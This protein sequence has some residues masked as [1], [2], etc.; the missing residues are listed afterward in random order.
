MHALI[1]RVSTLAQQSGLSFPGGEDLQTKLLKAPELA[2]PRRRLAKGLV[3]WLREHQTPPPELP[4]L[5]AEA[6]TW[7]WHG[8]SA[9]ECLT[10]GLL[11]VYLRVLR[12]TQQHAALLR[13]LEHQ[14]HRPRHD[15]TWLNAALSGLAS[16]ARE[17][18]DL[19]TLRRVATQLA[20]WFSQAGS[21]T[22]LAGLSEANVQALASALLRT[23][24]HSG[25]ARL[26]EA[27]LHDKPASLDADMAARLLQ[28][29]AQHLGAATA[30]PWAERAVAQ[31]PK[32]PGVRLALLHAL[33]GVGAGV[34]ELGPITQGVDDAHPSYPNFLSGVATRA[35]ESGH[36][37]AALGT[38]RELERRGHLSDL[39]AQQLSHLSIQDSSIAVTAVSPDLSALAPLQLALAPLAALLKHPPEHGTPL[40][41]AALRQQGE[42]ALAHFD[43]T[44]GQPPQLSISQ[45]VEAASTLWAMANA[46]PLELHHWRGV[47]PFDFGPD[48][49]RLDPQRA[50]VQCEAVLTHLLSL[51]RHHLG[52]L[53]HAACGQINEILR[54]AHWHCEAQWALGLATE[55]QAD[56]ASLQAR[57]APLG[58]WAL[59]A[60]RERCALEAGDLPAARM[61]RQHL[62]HPAPSQ[63][64]PAC[65]WAA[66]LA[67]QGLSEQRLCSDPAIGGRWDIASPK[68]RL[69]TAHFATLPT[70]L[71]M[72]ATRGLEVRHGHLLLSPTS[73][74][75]LPQAWHRQMGAFPFP[76]PKLLNRG[77]WGATL[78]VPDHI[79]RVS[80]PLL[81]LANM[82]ATFH[83]NYYHW[84]VLTL[85]RLHWAHA[86]GL[87]QGRR[88]LL[89]AELPG[90]MFQ[91]LIDAGVPAESLRR[92]RQDEALRLD[93]ALLLSPQEWASATQIEALCKTLWRSA[94]LN[95]E[96][97][98]PAQRLL[99]L[100]RHGEL[101]R[102][103]AQAQAVADLAAS[104]GFECVAPE[105]LS[106]LDQVRLFAQARGIAGPPGAAFTNLMW[107]QPGTKVLTVFKDEIN[108]PTFLDLSF[109]KGQQHRWLQGTSLP[110]FE[111][112]SVVTS[113]YSI[114][115]A[116]AER[117]LRWVAA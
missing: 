33:A 86:Q 56:M 60:L 108:S 79:E 31:Y 34:A 83:R 27:G 115:L 92:Y 13:T 46:G 72:V 17:C 80:E 32:H 102:P 97:P 12:Q 16:A 104:L 50:S 26:L 30:R 107:A 38:L 84:M 37:A 113:P 88:L 71:S 94:G 95:P 117:E 25:M 74:L 57:I 5:V 105:S 109:I 110:G 55:A 43:G 7:A 73:G 9:D 96:A 75:L 65:E 21:E 35:F 90:W 106:L 8:L 87:M 41:A 93:D 101:R 69:H 24:L 51:C 23:G 40:D 54:L 98:P 49:G 116:L 100:T 15:D 62:P 29:L 85:A 114:D 2:A 28:A 63:T 39:N 66:W 53:D 11:P 81:V 67:G 70:H 112:T 99:Y 14:A 77:L 20:C 3:A 76:H 6:I 52:Q 111:H 82:D 22:W 58:D 48:L 64:W 10:S 103:F 4:G 44:Q 78:Q 1:A 61:S 18:S 42:V 36:A 59:W 91:S 47:F 45:A 19:A 68:G 89:P